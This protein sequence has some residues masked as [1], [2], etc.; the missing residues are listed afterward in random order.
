MSYKIRLVRSQNAPIS[1]EEWKNCINSDLQMESKDGAEIISSA[2]EV[3]SA[4]IPNSARWT[5]HSHLKNVWFRWARGEIHV[6]NPD[7]ETLR[8]MQKIALV[9]GA[10]LRSED[11]E[12]LAMP[13]E[14]R[15]LSHQQ[16]HFLRASILRPALVID[17]AVF[18]GADASDAQHFGAFIGEKLAGVAYIL[19]NC[20]P[21]SDAPD[22]FQMRGVAVDENFRKRGVATALVEACLDAAESQ[23]GAILWCLARLVAV[24][25]YEK[26]GFEKIGAQFEIE[27]IGPH[28][29][30]RRVL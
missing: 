10:E 21:D 24:G 16:T 23:N 12:L 8:K 14:I 22:A 11:N 3:I 5:G 15:A 7:D 20:E 19:P 1:T 17:E 28:F 9:L 29:R 18:A 13:I 4:E 2:G 30:M 26:A 25:V 27:G 6:K